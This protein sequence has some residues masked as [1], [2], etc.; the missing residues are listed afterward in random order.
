MTTT[1][2]WAPRERGHSPLC[3]PHFAMLHSSLSPAV[4]LGASWPPIGIE[5]V[6]PWGV[7]LL[8]SCIL[9]AS[10]FILTLGHHGFL[11]GSKTLAITSI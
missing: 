9:L 4:E 5:A 11:A 10:G 1:A 3:V 2:D 8:G 6:D 7:P